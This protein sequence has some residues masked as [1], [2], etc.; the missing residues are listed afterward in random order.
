[1]FASFVGSERERRTHEHAEKG[2]E[3]TEQGELVRCDP[4]RAHV[5]TQERKHGRHA[6]KEDNASRESVM[7]RKKK[8][9]SGSKDTKI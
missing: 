6:C 8:M 5:H 4:L 9:S 2:C 1:M 7:V 3:R